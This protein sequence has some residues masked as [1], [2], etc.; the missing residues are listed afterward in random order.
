VPVKETLIIKLKLRKSIFLTAKD[1]AL[2]ADL[3]NTDLC[4][5]DECV[6][7]EK[8]TR[9]AQTCVNGTFR[10][11]TSGRLATCNTQVALSTTS[12]LQVKGL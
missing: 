4:M 2:S 10:G 6:W 9:L 5:L 7:V 3:L 1:T 11:R 8:A 12:D